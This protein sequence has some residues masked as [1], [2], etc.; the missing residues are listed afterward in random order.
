MIPTPGKPKKHCGLGAVNYHM[1]ETIVLFR[2]RRYRREVAELLQALVDKHPTGMMLLEIKVYA[3]SFRATAA[4]EFVKVKAALGYTDLEARH[5]LA[6][7]LG[8]NPHRTEVTYAYV[9]RNVLK[10][11]IILDADVHFEGTDSTS[12]P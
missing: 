12:Y 2:R 6:M 1:G 8:H 7:W 5:E 3:D 10:R 11:R 9:P 4:C